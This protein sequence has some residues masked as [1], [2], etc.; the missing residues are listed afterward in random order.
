MMIPLIFTGLVMSA[1]YNVVTWCTFKTW[2]FT[3]YSTLSDKTRLMQK[4]FGYAL[5][6]QVPLRTLLRGFAFQFYGL[7]R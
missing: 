1:I 6:F 3:K 5:L 7:R 4:Q 2:K